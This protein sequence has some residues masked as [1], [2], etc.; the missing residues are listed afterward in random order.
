MEVPPGHKACLPVKV[1]GQDAGMDVVIPIEAFPA[2]RIAYSINTLEPDGRTIVRLVN[3]TPNSI[4]VA[5]YK[6]IADFLLEGEEGQVRT[7][8]IVDQEPPIENDC[9]L[10]TWN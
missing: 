3:L 9:P 8:D 4:L 6:H 10:T 2:A 1:N 7:L 5:K